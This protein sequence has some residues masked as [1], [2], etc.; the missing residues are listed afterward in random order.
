MPPPFLPGATTTQTDPVRSRH[1]D[2]QSPSSWSE[3]GLPP[4]LRAPRPGPQ[5]RAEGTT[6]PSTLRKTRRQIHDDPRP[7]LKTQLKERTAVRCGH[8]FNDGRNH[9]EAELRSARDSGTEALGE[10]YNTVTG[11]GGHLTSIWGKGGPLAAQTYA[12][13]QGN[14]HPTPKVGASRRLHSRT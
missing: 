10:P 4:L 8:Q 9:A 3:P 13:S 14:M 6:R 11:K 7:Q 5:Q 2:L 1:L 12:I